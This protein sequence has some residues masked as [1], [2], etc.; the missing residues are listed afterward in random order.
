MYIMSQPKPSQN[1]TTKSYFNPLLLLGFAGDEGLAL[2]GTDGEVG[3]DLLGTELDGDD[4]GGLVGD[5]LLEFLQV[6]MG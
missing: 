2:A 4:V 6:K 5:L 1:Q 3:K